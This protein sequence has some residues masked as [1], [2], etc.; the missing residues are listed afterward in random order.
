MKFRLR[1][2][3]EVSLTQYRHE[4]I[5]IR[6]RTRLMSDGFASSIKGKGSSIR[7]LG[8]F[9]LVH[10]RALFVVQFDSVPAPALGVIHGLIR[11]CDERLDLV[12][13]WR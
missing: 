2:S 4:E 10:R 6:H 9:R 8:S 13:F 5:P 3:I 11:T 1:R 12:N 7:C